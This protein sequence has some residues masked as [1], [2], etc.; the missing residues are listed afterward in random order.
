MKDIMKRYLTWAGYNLGVREVKPVERRLRQIDIIFVIL[1]SIGSMGSILFSTDSYLGLFLCV[2][3]VIR[4][5]IRNI[6]MNRSVT[7]KIAVQ[8]IPRPRVFICA[9][10]GIKAIFDI[11]LSVIL[12]NTSLIWKVSI[13]VTSFIAL[14]VSSLDEIE[15]IVVDIL[16]GLYTVMLKGE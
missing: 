16:G 2:I 13:K 6:L 4:V 5:S 11:G 7:E 8:V 14:L 9:Y 1:Y 12:I 15:C 3:C 10:P